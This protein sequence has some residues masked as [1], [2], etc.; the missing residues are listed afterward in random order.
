MTAICSAMYIVT[1]FTVAQKWKKKKKLC[2][3]TDEWMKRMWCIYT[4]EYYSF[5]RNNEIISF[6]TTWKD[7]VK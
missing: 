4:L 1:L 6:A 3:L 7:Q 2:L 5:I